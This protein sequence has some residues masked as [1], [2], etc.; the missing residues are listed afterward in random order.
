MCHNL[1]ALS[2]KAAKDSAQNWK[3]KGGKKGGRED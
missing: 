3:Q 2:L 1:S